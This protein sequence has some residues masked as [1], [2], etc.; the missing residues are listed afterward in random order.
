MPA[1]R[2][3][4]VTNIQH[5]NKFKVFLVLTFTFAV[6]GLGKLSGN[7]LTTKYGL[8]QHVRS[9]NIQVMFL[10]TKRHSKMRVGK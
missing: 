9:G 3:D 7:C 4:L 5:P 2:S 6:Y 1:K 8:H 10:P